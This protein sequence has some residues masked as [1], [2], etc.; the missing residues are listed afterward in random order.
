M[1]QGMS[2]GIVQKLIHKA[3]SRQ[4]RHLSQYL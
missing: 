2:R 1:P 3:L 4:D